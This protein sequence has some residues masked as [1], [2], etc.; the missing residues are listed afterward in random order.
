M[1][2]DR[3]RTRDRSGDGDDEFHAEFELAPEFETDADGQRPR[4]GTEKASGGLR[5]RAAER[6]G[7]LFAPR[8]FLAAL[9]LTAG[10]VFAAGT[11]IPL[12]GAGLLGI[13][14]ATFLFGL[15]T[16]ERRY[17]ETALAG[18]LAAAV[19]TLLDFAVVA[20]L[21]GVGISL[22]ALA[23][24]IGAIV[25]AAGMYFGRDLRDGLTREL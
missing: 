25:A 1:S 11:V 13:F 9:L 21:G 23:G 24:G 8:I 19:S 14:A 22:A 6:A 18:G 12:P 20:F 15:V 5:A 16:S 17:A 7:T 3:T 2:R 4:A 10:G